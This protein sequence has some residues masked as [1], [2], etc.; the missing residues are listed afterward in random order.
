MRLL[1]C[2]QVIS[3]CSTKET[4]HDVGPLLNEAADENPGKRF[5]CSMFC[6]GFHEQDH[7]QFSTHSSRA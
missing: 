6:L 2:K 1:E 5:K 7:F 3:T 4:K